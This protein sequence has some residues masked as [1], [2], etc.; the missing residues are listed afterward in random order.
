MNTKPRLPEDV[1]KEAARK[2]INEEKKRRG[3]YHEDL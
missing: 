2:I 1:A 3:I